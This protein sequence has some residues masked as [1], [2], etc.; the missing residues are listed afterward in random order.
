VPGEQVVV[1][2]GVGVEVGGDAEGVQA[3]VVVEQKLAAD[4]VAAPV[5]PDGE[6]GE[7][8]V[9]PGGVAGPQQPVQVLPALQHRRHA[10]RSGIAG[11]AADRGFRLNGGGRPRM[12]KPQGGADDL[13][14]VDGDVH[15]TVVQGVLDG[16]L[17]EAEAVGAAQVGVGHHPAGDL[18]VRDCV[19]EQP[20]RRPQV[21]WFGRAD[22][23]G[24]GR[25]GSH[26]HRPA[27]RDP[28]GAA[29]CGW[30][31]GAGLQATAP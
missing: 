30:C 29:S 9:R 24:Q 5:G 11:R 1:V 4:A 10:V 22:G 12:G 15:D 17:D 19:G 14:P 25:S 21:G 23:Q 27:V 7:V 16:Y 31:R 18:A 8:A 28:A 20:D 26:G 3:G 2:A 13:A 6:V